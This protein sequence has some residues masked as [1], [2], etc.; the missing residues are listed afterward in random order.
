[1]GLGVQGGKALGERLCLGEPPGFTQGGQPHPQ[2]Q[3]VGP[4]GPATLWPL[5]AP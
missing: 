2:Q 3:G 1:V 5:K 4:R